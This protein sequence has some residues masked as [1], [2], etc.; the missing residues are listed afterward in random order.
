M[1]NLLKSSTPR[2]TLWQWVLLGSV[3]MLAALPWI[4]NHDYIRDFMDYGL[5][6]AAIGRIDAGEQVYQ[7]FTTPI[8]AGFLH[9]NRVA[10]KMGGGGYLGL[11]YGG[12]ALIILSVSGLTWVLRRSLSTGWAIFFATAV[13]VS[14]ASQHTIIWHN[15]LGVLCLAAALWATA[16]APQWNRGDLGLHL[17]L[18]LA[19]W[20]SG[21]NKLNFHLLALVGVC[22]FVIRGIILKPAD[23]RTHLGLMGWIALSGILLPLAT[24]LGLSGAS[25]TL[26]HQNVLALAGSSRAE[27][28]TALLGWQTYL[29]PI[30]AYY[31][32]LPIPAFGLWFVVSMLGLV[33]LLFRHRSR[34]DLVMLIIACLGCAIAANALLVTNQEIAYVSGGA[35]IA[36]AVALL[37]A[38]SPEQN[39]P[40][41][42]LLWVGCFAAIN[43]LPAWKSAWSGERSQFGHSSAARADYV[44]LSAMNAN[45]S[46][47]REVKFPPEIAESY[48]ALE[49]FMPKADEN[50]EHAVL[51]ATGLEW[52]E[53]VWPAI[54]VNGLPLWMHDGTTY[55][56]PQSE[57]LYQLI[58]PPSHFEALITAVPWDHWPGQSHVAAALFSEPRDCGSWIRVNTTQSS[59][60]R[61]ND[62]IRLINL[63][64]TN[65]ETRLLRFGNSVFRPTE[66]GQIFFG[67]DHDGTAT[68]YLDWKGSR[69]MA[70]GIIRRLDPISD[71]AMGASFFIEYNVDGDWHLIEERRL[72]LAPEESEKNFEV[73][74]D[75][76]QRELRFRTILDEGIEEIASSGW[77][78][79][80]LLHSSPTEGPPPPLIRHPLPESPATE[81]RLK[82][83]NHTD[84]IPDDIFLRG[85]RVTDEGYLLEPGGQIWLKV[86]HPLKALNGQVT[87]PKSVPR[88][89]VMPLVRVLWY[90][91]GRVQIARQ[92]RLDPTSRHH[93]FH[94]WSAG[95]DGW[96]GILMDP[97]PGV[98]PVVVE[99][100]EVIPVP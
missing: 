62:Q 68:V 35:C 53:R 8:Q 16:R 85:G 13:T 2:M 33:A 80:T 17:V 52:L 28:L 72:E 3:A 43:G 29:E 64:G 48:A 42:A 95:P 73:L 15:T 10:E 98:A 34:S 47:V 11:T 4:R 59:L 83:F 37:I 50:G 22:G 67:T 90:K 56:R 58:M 54:K 65:F 40:Q 23:F 18:G 82:A 44:E 84:W 26:W 55:Q 75:G 7:D 27:Y 94:S 21:I 96:I 100:N 24:E 91:G 81:E 20:I 6:V 51:Y 76:R 46:Y 99:I 12:L 14:T 71:E 77:M 31:G 87:V 70:K 86:N 92:E 89:V 74:F 19:L 45:F 63:F 78:A 30:H 49:D 88:G 57:L 32:S 25:F 1:V 38:F 41:K 93:Q 97:L 69:A 60:H 36:L 5:V 39:V 9:L 61:D 79:P 66:D